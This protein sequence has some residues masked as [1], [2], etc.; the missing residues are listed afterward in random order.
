LVGASAPATCAFNRFELRLRFV[1][2]A[3]LIGQGLRLPLVGGREL[4]DLAYVALRGLQA[5]ERLRKL[6]NAALAASGRINLIV[7][8][9]G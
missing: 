5:T 4:D 3:V 2:L 8:G 6:V 7:D 1:H 9:S